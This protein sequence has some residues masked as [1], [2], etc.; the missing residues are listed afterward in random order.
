MN[1]TPT[2][3][4]YV[5]YACGCK[6]SG[7]G[8]LPDY[9]GAHPQ[10]TITKSTTVPLKSHLAAV[11]TPLITVPERDRDKM[12]KQLQD[13]LAD[14]QAGRIQSFMYGAVLNTDLAKSPRPNYKWWIAGATYTSDIAML[15]S[16]FNWEIDRLHDAAIGDRSDK[17]P[18]DDAA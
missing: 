18:P 16:I 5:E 17:V 12:A 11:P 3:Y 14:V 1:D 13:L 2:I 7:P 15:V 8:Q 4:Q 9:C 10:H 6:A